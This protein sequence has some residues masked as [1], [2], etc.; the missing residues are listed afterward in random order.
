[1]NFWTVENGKLVEYQR[2]G[3][4]T[5]CGRCCCKHKIVF[6]MEVGFNSGNRE[7]DGDDDYDWAEREGWNMFYAQGIW[8]YFK[9]NSITDDGQDRCPELDDDKRC[10]IF[11][12]LAEW[13][14]IC[15]YWPFHP[16]DL[17][18]FP[19]CGFSF[20]KVEGTEEV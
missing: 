8:W 4:C 2:F 5:A 14:P 16:N 1:M 7:D 19:D 15:R 12:D 9:I 18:K 17:E 3:E 10:K 13:P 20:E 11:G 6:Q